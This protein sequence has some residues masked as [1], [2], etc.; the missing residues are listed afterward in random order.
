MRRLLIVVV[1]AAALH[2]APAAAQDACR[3]GASALSDARALAA[4]RGAI[5]EA[6]PCASYDGTQGKT[7][8]AYRRCA[9]EVLRASLASGGLRPQC[10]PVAIR[11][12]LDTT[13]GAPGKVTCGRVAPA[14]RTKPVSCRVTTP[15][16]CASRGGW[17]ETA[18]AAQTHCADVVEWTAGTCVDPREPGPFA[19]GV[20]TLA[21]TKP[22]VETGEPR[23]LDTLV[24]YPASPGAGPLDPTLRAVV[25]APVADAGAPF[26]VVVFS[27][28]MCGSPRQSLFLT[29]LLASQGFVVVA[30]PHPGNTT[31]DIPFCLTPES[32]VSSFRERPHDV[33]FV[34]DQMLAASAEPGSPF[35]GTL[36]ADRV[37]MSGHSFGGLTTYLVEDLE[38]RIKVAIPM[39]PAILN[40]PS[41]AIPS[42][43]LLGQV[44]GVLPVAPM[45]T[46]WE[47][48][49]A[50]K[51]LVEIEHAGHYAFSDFC[52]PGS[53]CKPPE[54]LTS[55]EA[56]A[57][58]L[59][60]VR[61]FLEVHLN[62]DQGFAP[63]FLAPEP[64]V[65]L[66]AE[67]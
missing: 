30:P 9:R 18:C 51:Y 67:R 44:D 38:P 59:R 23:T 20:R 53:D 62:G 24:W 46:A 1:A 13:C 26:P 40:Q 22:S 55:D 41:L 8:S 10:R 31:A 48:S 37:G 43:T 28:G 11:G 39:A 56:H 50:P 64:G 17:T 5:D 47:A 12:Y 16:R 57:H 4:L 27:H 58:V 32:L 21:Y 7:R 61:P 33:R 35:F 63:F 19:A 25:D 15:E 6:C 34:L 29:P 3:A 42:L 36:D 49:A 52:R 54:T 45:R 65:V 66:R 14:S 2:A 60:W